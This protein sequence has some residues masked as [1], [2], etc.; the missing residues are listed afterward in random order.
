MNPCGQYA[1]VISLI[2]IHCGQKN[3][4]DVLRSAVP[5]PLFTGISRAIV[6]VFSRDVHHTRRSQEPIYL[7]EVLQDY[8]CL[9]ILIRKSCYIFTVHCVNVGNTPKK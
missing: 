4:T 6:S 2:F 1:S 5:Q 9:Q 3:Y 8:C 7:M